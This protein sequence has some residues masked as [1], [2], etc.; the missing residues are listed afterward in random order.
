[1]K[2]Y[3][4]HNCQAAHRTYRTLVR[5]M[6]P[7][8]AW[9]A[10]EGQYALIAWCDV[11]TVSLHDDLANAIEKKGFI[12]RTRCGGRCTGHHDIVQIVKGTS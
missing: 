1:M 2:T 10:G 11:P 6:I 3:R 5:C 9:V 4:I 12:D 8:A 7:K